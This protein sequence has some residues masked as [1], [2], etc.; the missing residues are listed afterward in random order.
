MAGIYEHGNIPSVNIKGG[1][2]V[3]LLRKASLIHKIGSLIEISFS[4][5]HHRSRISCNAE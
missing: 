1:K 3:C 4:F 2:F 5:P